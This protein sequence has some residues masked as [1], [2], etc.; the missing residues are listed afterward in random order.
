MKIAFVQKIPYEII[1]VQ[2]LSA[3]AK[4][5]GHKTDV[6]IADIDGSAFVRNVADYH[7]DLIAFS[8][9]SSDYGWFDR[10]LAEIKKD[11]PGVPVVA[12][13]PHPT[14]F[15]EMIEENDLQT[16]FLGESEDSFTEYLQ[17]AQNQQS[18][19]N[20]PGT[21]HKDK[22]GL[23]HRNLI[24]PL[25]ARLD[26]LP[27]PDF[28]LYF[29]K[30]PI[31]G[32]KILKTFIAS[33]GCCFACS[34]CYNDRYH[35]LYRG[36]GPYVRHL[37]PSKIIEWIDRVRS[38]YPM[39]IVEFQDDAFTQ[40][41]PWL[42]DFLHLYKTRVD[43][44]FK[45][46]VRADMVDDEV[47]RLLKKAGALVVVFG[48]E[49]GNQEIRNTILNKNINNEQIYK[50][51]K[52]LRKHGLKFGTSNM[53]GLPTESLD[54]AFQT[55]QLNIDIRTDYP[56]AAVFMPFPNTKIT[57]F[58]QAKKL[59]RADYDFKNLPSSFFSTSPLKLENKHAFENL[60]K[61]FYFTVRYP[62]T[63]PFMKKIIHLKWPF[64][65]RSIFAFS[66]LCK[67]AEEKKISKLKA[68]GILWSF[69]HSI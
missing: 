68:F 43:L 46:L 37:P 5:N 40:N 2:Y 58:A 28:E 50:C 60:H 11:H 15:P 23:I 3:I 55:V 7:P 62:W 33:R 20:I 51:A 44:P 52:I 42:K 36:Q 48:I 34:F 24:S 6:F 54:K 47:A 61:V 45:C 16:V 38:K 63:F 27:I 10:V 8:L 53:F 69:R 17:K 32:Q 26:S 66:Y 41:K 31:L 35:K 14:F 4:K 39:E 25:N 19:N 67:Y 65:F 9:M 22:S 64:F 13:G 57:Q 56:W 18:L 12:G 30:Y 29:S 21:W 59:L 49:T 1:G